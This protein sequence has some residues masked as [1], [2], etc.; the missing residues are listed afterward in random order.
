MENGSRS[1]GISEI[2]VSMQAASCRLESS[3]AP[4]LEFARS[5][6]HGMVRSSGEEPAVI[7]KLLWDEHPQKTWSGDVYQRG[8]RL[9]QEYSGGKPTRLLLTEIQELPGLQIAMRWQDGILLVDAYYRVES[10]L[11]RAAGRFNP[12]LPRA[13]VILIYYLVYFPLVYSLYLRKGWHLFHAGAVEKEGS[14]WVFAG[15]PGSGK[16]T[17]TLSLLSKPGVNLLSDNLL[18]FDGIQVYACP[19]PLH[20]GKESIEVVGQDVLSRLDDSQ[21][22]FS[23]GRHDYR[24]GDDRR[25]NKASAEHLVFLGL[26][27]RREA[28]SLPEALALE[29]LAGYDLMAKEVNAYEQFAVSLDLLVSKKESGSTGRISDKREKLAA[30]VSKMDCWDLWVEKGVDLLRSWSWLEEL[31]KNEEANNEVQHQIGR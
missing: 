22:K 17:F 15:L 10:R 2:T 16:T 29:R 31:I 27:G 6:M 19:E 18:L 5:Y 20:L 21:R 26:A 24:L 3:N 28:R 12:L 1:S 11:A 30:L 9:L 14:G 4:F 7:S 25:V 23:H 13:Y 8:R